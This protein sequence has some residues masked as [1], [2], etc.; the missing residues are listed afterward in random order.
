MLPLGVTHEIDAVTIHAVFFGRALGHHY[1]VALAYAASRGVGLACG[2]AGGRPI[3]SGGKDGTVAGAVATG[4][5]AA[6]RRN[7]N[8]AVLLSF[9]R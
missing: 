1:D 3:G 6:E 2:F 9:F 4:R 7:H 5:A 8:E